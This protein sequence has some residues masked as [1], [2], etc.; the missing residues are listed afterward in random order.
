MKKRT[1]IPS[2]R[3]RLELQAAG[4]IQPRRKYKPHKLL[5]AQGGIRLPFVPYPGLY[6][7]YERPRRRSQSNTL[8]LRVRTVE[9]SV[10]KREFICVV[11]EIM[12]SNVLMETMEVRDSPRIE[13]HFVQLQKIL[14]GFGFDVD[15]RA[16]GVYWA[17]DKYAD[18]APITPQ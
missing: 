1:E 9:W 17:L 8:Y 2:F 14:V 10:R 6:L 5:R 11:D 13:E 12:G 7:T 4:P 3:V 15:P 18:G 16:D